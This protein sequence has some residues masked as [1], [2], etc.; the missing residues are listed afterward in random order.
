M[1]RTPMENKPTFAR[2]AQVIRN[3]PLYSP[4]ITWYA[5]SIVRGTSITS[6]IY[7]GQA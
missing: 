7:L 3:V 1:F 4:V 6:Y 5:A 2:K